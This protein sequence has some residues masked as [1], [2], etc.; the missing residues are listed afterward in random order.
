MPYVRNQSIRVI[1]TAHPGSPG[2]IHYDLNENNGQGPKQEIDFDNKKHPG[3]VVY[4]NLE[5]STGQGL[6]FRP[7][8][9]EALWVNYSA[10]GAPA[11]SC[12]TKAAAWVG[13]IPLSVEKYG[14]QLIVYCRNLDKLQKFKFAL[15]FLDGNGAPVVDYDPI[16]NGNNGDRL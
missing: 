5:D 1:A 14:K 4:F 16:G 2:G 7:V 15:R 13:F 11:P 9:S 12:P 10:P 6:V 8:P 3:I